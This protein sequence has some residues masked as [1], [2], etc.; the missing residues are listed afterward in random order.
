M[1]EIDTATP[2]KGKVTKITPLPEL[3]EAFD[4]FAC[5]FKIGAI[6]G[7]SL[8]KQAKKDLIKFLD[9]DEAQQLIYGLLVKEVGEKGAI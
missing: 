2:G 4:I 8:P 5:G 6:F 7:K 1:S 3:K 9:S